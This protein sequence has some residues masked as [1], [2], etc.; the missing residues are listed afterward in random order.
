M[1]ILLLSGGYDST[2]LAWLERPGLALTI[3]Y[4]Q[5]PVRGEIR[6]SRAICDALEIPH[7]ILTLNS[8]ALGSGDLAGRPALTIAPSSEWWPFRNQ[9]LLTVASMRAMQSN[10]RSI[11]IGT[12]NTDSFHADG[13]LEFIQHFNRLLAAQEGGLI[14]EAPGIEWSTAE[15]IQ[16]SKIPRHILAWSHS[17]HIAEWA[18]GSCRG[19]LKSLAVRIA[20]GYE[21]P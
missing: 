10:A 1:K 2:A 3:D 17:C 14:V 18:C 11:I 16:V 8:Q 13:R 7:E 21:Q 19:C 20:L 4:G 5:L 15:L 6:A 12:V 9:L